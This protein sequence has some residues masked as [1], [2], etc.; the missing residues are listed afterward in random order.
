[1]QADSHSDMITIGVD[2]GGAKT[3]IGVFKR[4]GQMLAKHVIPTGTKET[5]GVLEA[6]GDKIREVIER[7]TFEADDIAGIGLGICGPVTKGGVVLKCAN[8]DLEEVYPQEVFHRIL[9]EIKGPVRCCNN[10]NAAAL[11]E[12]FKGAAKGREDVLLVRIGTGLGAGVVTNGRIVTGFH[13]LSGEIGHLCVNKEET[14]QCGCGLY[15]CLE[16]YVSEPGMVREA[17]QLLKEHP[18]VP[19]PLRNLLEGAAATDRAL[20]TGAVLPHMTAVDIFNAAHN[21][22]EIAEFVVNHVCGMLGKALAFV[23]NVTAPEVILLGG[24]VSRAAALAIGQVKSSYR[25]TVYPELNGIPIRL[26]ALGGDAGMIGADYLIEEHLY[27]SG[28][29]HAGL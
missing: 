8:I 5:G 16:Q 18:E 4:G 28:A 24:D 13:G 20:Q 22:D 21:G 19:S 23:A 11:G 7:G 3:K 6:V 17:H 29:M 25:R 12:M 10:A 27:G 14:R 1:M 26:A 15:G 2:I 9:P